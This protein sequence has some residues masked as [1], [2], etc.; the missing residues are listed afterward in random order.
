MRGALVA[1]SLV[2]RLPGIIPADAGSTSTVLDPETA[3][4]DHPRGCGE[5]AAKHLGRHY[6]GGSSP[7]M[8]GALSHHP[9][10]LHHSGIIPADAGSTTGVNPEIYVS[11]D[12]PR[13]CGEHVLKNPQIVSKLSD[14]EGSSPRM[15]GALPQSAQSRGGLRIIPAD[16]GSTH[17]ISEYGNMVRDHPRGCG[18][19][20]TKAT[21]AIREAG[22][23]PRMRGALS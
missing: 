13:G 23:S 10:M 22:S 20:V 8:R 3:D 1:G 12:H 21:K 2:G 16:A 7:R 17:S 9:R 6:V 18:E 19:H 4:R 11:E 15:R 14:D 5:H